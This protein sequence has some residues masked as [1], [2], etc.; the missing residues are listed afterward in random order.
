MWK[1]L[2]VVF[3][4]LIITSCSYFIPSSNDRDLKSNDY[5]FTIDKT[6]WK[7]ADPDI[8]DYA[9]Y[10]PST[11]SHLILNS[12]CKKYMKTDVKELVNNLLT[13]IKKL[14]IKN[15]S[16]FKLYNRDAVKVDGTGEIDGVDFKFIVTTFKRNR[17]T[18]D[19]LFLSTQKRL[20]ARE[21]ETYQNLINSVSFK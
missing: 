14:E 13:G 4:M 1:N 19:F 12:I 11:G 9:Y 8:A 3:M 21:V 10:N 6:K 17:C 15:T 18:F 7:L 20:P 16:N 5:T 2:R